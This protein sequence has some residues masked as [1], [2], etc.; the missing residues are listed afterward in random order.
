MLRTSLTDFSIVSQS[1]SPVTFDGSGY[2]VPLSSR[3]PRYSMQCFSNLHFSG[4]RKSECSFIMLST[5]L[6]TSLWYSRSSVVAI[7]ILSM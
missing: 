5:T 2:T 1:Q 7:R 4:L 6:T 3:I